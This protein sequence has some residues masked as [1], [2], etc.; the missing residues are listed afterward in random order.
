MYRNFIIFFVS[1]A[2]L[3]LLPNGIWADTEG[4]YQVFSNPRGIYLLLS[5]GKLPE[6]RLLKLD[7]VKGISIRVRWRDIE[8]GPSEF[9]WSY[10]DRMFSLAQKEHKKVFLRLLGGFWAPRWIYQK[11]VPSF[12][13]ELQGTGPAASAFFQRYGK[14]VK[15]PKVWDETYIKYWT[16][17]IKAVGKRYADRNNLVLVHLSGPTFFSAELIMARNQEELKTLLDRG[18]S[19]DKLLNAWQKTFMYFSNAFPRQYLALNVHYVIKERPELVKKIF[20][21]A[22]SS[23]GSRLALQGNWLSPRHIHWLKAKDRLKNPPDEFFLRLFRKAREVGIIIGFQTA[24]PLTL[25]AERKGVPPKKFFRIVKR[26]LLVTCK[27]GA[28][29]LELYPEDISNELLWPLWRR[30]SS[31]CAISER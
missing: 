7:F 29:Y 12:E 27:L 15:L 22:R 19:E 31:H 13:I 16:S 4:S 18:F 5:A 14:K 6:N 11:G 25:I 24:A 21:L 23:L 2:I 20:K 10:L 26:M 8:K 3:F 17:F 9:D 28:C 1:L 30:F